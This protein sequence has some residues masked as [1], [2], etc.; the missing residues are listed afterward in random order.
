MGDQVIGPA[1]D[2]V[3]N[4]AQA[5]A[6]WAFTRLYESLAPAVVGYL[7]A[8]GVKDPEDVASEVF[9]S[10]FCGFSSFT[11]NEERFRSWVF[12]IAYR[13]LIDYRR[14]SSRRPAP[15]RLDEAD[16]RP[17]PFSARVATDEDALA[18]LGTERVRRVL[19]QLAPDQA[20]VLALRVIADLT[21]D[22]VAL[23]LGKSPG[24]V[25]ALQRRAL[26]NLR[27]I[28]PAEGVPL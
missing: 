16:G 12:T 4:A 10:V 5:G 1:F 7:R 20:D 19:A 13:R 3:L 27:R 24:A 11:G 9:L 26:A 21:V 23:A 14:A 15:E 17:E 8:Q 18:R 25:K 28:L 2:Q 22:Q 6:G